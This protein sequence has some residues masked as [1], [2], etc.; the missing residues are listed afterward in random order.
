[1]VARAPGV[2]D[3]CDP[4]AVERLFAGLSAHPKDGATAWALLFY[5]LWHRRHMLGLKPVGDVFAALAHS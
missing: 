4:A 2:A 3:I 1:L 5:A